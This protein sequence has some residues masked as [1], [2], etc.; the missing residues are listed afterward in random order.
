MISDQELDALIKKA[1][2]LM[3][4]DELAAIE[5]RMAEE[6]PH[7]FSKEYEKKKQKIL[8]GCRHHK[9]VEPAVEVADR[10]PHWTGRRPKL[11]YL[12]VAVLLLILSATTVLAYEPLKVLLEEIVYT[13]FPSHVSID[14]IEDGKNQNESAAFVAKRPTEVP[15]GY[16]LVMEDVDEAM[17]MCYLVWENDKRERI[18]YY[19]YNPENVGFSVTADGEPP[20][21]VK[22]GNTTA[23]MV[24]DEDKFR[25]IIY[26]E[27]GLIYSL[28]SK[29]N[30]RQMIKILE[31]VK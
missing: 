1:V 29:L 16:K 8:N 27:G 19:Q 25:T 24:V 28:T 2:P 13:V 20:V 18:T 7:V 15:E 22:V 3:W 10:K 31:S 11:R 6:S 26:E 14:E 12:L 9:K 23:K 17:N 4:Y 5:K 21:D 30:K